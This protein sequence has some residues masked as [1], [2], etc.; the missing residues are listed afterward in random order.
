[1][2][3]QPRLNFLT[4]YRCYMLRSTKPGCTNRT[5]VGYSKNPLKR[6]RQH[7]GE[8]V[9]GAKKTKKCRPWEFICIISGFPNKRNAL[10]FEWANHHPPIKKFG[11]DYRIKNLSKILSTS[12]WT[13]T[14]LPSK[15]MTIHIQW[16]KIGYHLPYIPKNCR[17]CIYTITK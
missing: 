7:N 17:E 9:G 14:A 4:P 13:K 11:I 6:L 16:F 3:G 1:M 15:L 2:S 5:Y 10:Q 12:R 8:I